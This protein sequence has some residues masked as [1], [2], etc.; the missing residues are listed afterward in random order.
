[1]AL[2][3]MGWGVSHL[4]T[5]LVMGVLADR[6]GIVTGFYVLGAVSLVVVGLVAGLRHWAFART[7]LAPA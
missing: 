6:Y 3:G 1:M 7:K 2:G 4:T 5:P